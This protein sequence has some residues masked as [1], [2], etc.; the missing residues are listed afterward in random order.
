MLAV[1]TID[2][3]SVSFLSNCM[4]NHSAERERIEEI[5]DIAECDET[6]LSLIE[7]VLSAVRSYIEA[8]CNMEGSLSMQRFRL[9]GEEIRAL[10]EKLDGKRRRKHNVLIDS[11]RIANRY[12]FK[13]FGSEMPVGGVYS[14]DPLHLCSDCLNRDAIGDWAK[15]VVRAFANLH[16]KMAPSI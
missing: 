16:V 2:T 13:K 12:L 3:N 11:V 1:S 5:L 14:G 9:E 6:A 7:N 10:T 8:I 15:G 4:K